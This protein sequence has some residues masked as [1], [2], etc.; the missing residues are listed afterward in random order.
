MTTRIGIVADDLTGAGDT[1]VQFVRAGWQTELRLRPAPTSATSA[2]VIAVT[3]DSRTQG[4]Q[5]ATE[6][7]ST[8]VKQLRETAV[9]HLY[10]KIDSTLRG[11]I[12]AEIHAALDAWSPDAV[13][14][15]CPAFPPAGRTIANGILLVN[16]IEVARTAVASDPVTPVTESHIPTVL[17]AAH[18]AQ[19]SSDSAEALAERLKSSG[20]VVV[21]DAN[22]EDDLRRLAEAIALLGT[23]AIAVGSAGLAR[24]LAL[25]W[26]T[27]A[28]PA[29]VLVTS[30]NDAARR[31]AAAV[32]NAGASRF[33]PG[34]DDLVDDRAWARLSAKILD[35]LDETN[36][37]VLLT[38]PDDR[39][40][41]LPAALI[42][43][44]FAE[45]AARIITHR[46]HTPHGRISGVVV[47]GGD[48]ARAQ[49][50]AHDASAN[51]LR[52][53]V[54]TGVTIG[55]LVGGPADGMAVVTKAG[56]F[57]ADDTLVH[58]VESVR[59]RRF[60]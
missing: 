33:E 30:L 28:A 25:A 19:R 37:T 36:S 20:R 32:E 54:V 17:G 8:A 50:D 41:G 15:V 34:P 48:G 16:G 55:T 59:Y 23:R 12:R 29:V 6:S 22:S 1:A 52:D 43:Q 31:Q 47:T 60:A 35:R 39:S 44:R 2:H 9:T 3:T 10:K 57:G 42:P 18:A 58:A 13:A 24:H 7:V 53:E 40:H 49:V 56:G 26:R 27:P 45:L 11:Q 14:V 21:V 4:A 51:K 38:A 46:A 5:Q